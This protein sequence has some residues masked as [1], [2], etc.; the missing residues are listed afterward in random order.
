MAEIDIIRRALEAGSDFG[1]MTQQRADTLVKSLVEAGEVQRDQAQ[2]LV[3]DIVER[4]K[5]NRERLLA[6]IDR[7][8]KNSVGRMGLATKKDVDVLRQ[9]VATLE[10]AAKKPPAK[11]KVKK[12]APAA[13]T[14]TAAK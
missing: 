3:T 7:E 8:V 10:K 5:E 12:K 9:K 13:K 1:Q 4:S 14:A 2:K 6:T 11:K